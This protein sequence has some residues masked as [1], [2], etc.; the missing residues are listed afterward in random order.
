MP[1]N[2]FLCC[3]R[4]LMLARS[5]LN[6]PGSLAPGWLIRLLTRKDLYLG[7]SILRAG[8]DFLAELGD[9]LVFLVVLVAIIFPPPYPL[10]RSS[11]AAQPLD[12]LL[13]WRVGAEHGRDVFAAQRIGE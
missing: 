12:S 10:G 13:Y 6:E 8:A 11:H 5:N 7:A 3:Q 9:F 1:R 4:W 2:N